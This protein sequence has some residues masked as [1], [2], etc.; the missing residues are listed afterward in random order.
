[1][2]GGYTVLPANVKP[3]VIAAVFNMETP[4]DG[5]EQGQTQV[6]AKVIVDRRMI[7]H[8]VVAKQAVAL[9]HRFL[10]S[11]LCHHPGLCGSDMR[12]GVRFHETAYSN[13][14]RTPIPICSVHGNAVSGPRIFEHLDQ[15]FGAN[16]VQASQLHPR[17][18]LELL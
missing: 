16:G 2:G 14:Q 6:C 7:L 5:T 17:H 11:V 8:H 3:H 12:N 10:L 4:V 9:G 13:H 15:V 18:L 1:M